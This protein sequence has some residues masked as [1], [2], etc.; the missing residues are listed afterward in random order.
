PQLDDLLVALFVGDEAALELLV[1]VADQ[2][3]GGLE[4]L[5][6]LGRGDDVPQAYGH[7]ATGGELEADILDAVDEVRGVGRA[8]Q[9]VALIDEALEVG[10]AHLPVGQ[11]GEPKS[12]R[13]DLVE[14]DPP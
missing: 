14:D 7:A 8:E 9:P 10:P 1:D 5:R 6:L 2:A 3:I 13:D 4:R 11:L 12:I